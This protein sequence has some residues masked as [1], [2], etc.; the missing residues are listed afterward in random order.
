MGHVDHQAAHRTLW[1]IS[2]KLLKSMVLGIRGR[3]GDD[4]LRAV[5][6]DQVLDLVIVD[7]AGVGVDTVG[8]EVVEL[9]GRR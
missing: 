1:A 4:Q 6:L 5:L 8:D 2:P 9:A 7:A 3:T